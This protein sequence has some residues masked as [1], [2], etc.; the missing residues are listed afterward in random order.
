MLHK[1][2]DNVDWSGS[3]EK[4]MPIS[5]EETA[6]ASLQ[7]RKDYKFTFHKIQLAAILEEV[8]EQYDVMTIDGRQVFNYDTLYFG[9][10][11]LSLY[12]DHHNGKLNRYKVR[13]RRYVDTGNTFLEI[14][15]KNN[16]GVTIKNRMSIPQMNHELTEESKR[17]I[18]ENTPLDASRLKAMLKTIYQRITLVSKDKSERVT[19]DLGL[20]F[21][22]LKNQK[23]LP[24]LVV[25][26]VKTGKRT[27]ESIIYN[28]LKAR[29]IYPTSFSKYCMGIVKTKKSVKKNNFKPI[30]RGLI[31][32]GI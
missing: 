29:K 27:Q 24:N 9:F 32:M 6:A 4:F 31:K 8:H 23:G 18:E 2:Y 1:S 20:E 13:C 25:L 11:D 12:L 14:K 7:S 16:K 21:D 19:I 10:P 28:V 17:Y 15:F 3:L 5:L 30:E 26:E 22:D